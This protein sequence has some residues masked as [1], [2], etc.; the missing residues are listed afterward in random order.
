[1]PD[2]LL[3]LDDYGIILREFLRNQFGD[4]S[5]PEVYKPR[6]DSKGYRLHY[7]NSD[8]P[9]EYLLYDDGS[10][11][12][13]V[14]S[15]YDADDNE[16]VLCVCPSKYRHLPEYTPYVFDTDRD[17]HVCKYTKVE[18]KNIL[19]A[20]LYDVGYA[21]DIVDWNS[22]INN[23]LY[24]AFDALAQFEDAS[25]VIISMRDREVYPFCNVSDYPSFVAHRKG[26]KWLN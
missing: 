26:V 12:T 10:G 3:D 5:Y 24:H 14:Y 9:N 4:I 25:D 8:P 21:T 20:L 13:A 6:G 1:M 22:A 11:L 7:D 15:N 19:R 17:R 16:V 23:L 18:L 2:V